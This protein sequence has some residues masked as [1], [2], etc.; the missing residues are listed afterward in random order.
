METD[1]NKKIKLLAGSG[2]IVLVTYIFMKRLFLIFLPFFVALLV[3]RALERPVGFLS[4]RIGGKRGVYAGI[5]MVLITLIL[6][7][8][9]GFLVYRFFAE[10]RS[11]VGNFQYNMVAV[12]Q[13][14]AR[15]CLRLDDFLGLKSG[16]CIKCA[17][18]FENQIGRMVDD[19]KLSVILGKCLSVSIPIVRGGIVVLASFFVMIIGVIYLSA[20]LDNIRRAR[21]KSV[22]RRE[23]GFV[24]DSLNLLVSV[25][26]RVQLLILLVNSLVCVLALYLT[27]NPYALLFGILIGILD[28]LPFFGTGTV[29]IPWAAGLLIIKNVP[30]ALILLGAYVVTYFVREIM[31]SKLMGK[32][33]GI[34]PFTMLM[35]IFVGIFIYGPLGFIMGPISYCIIKPLILCLKTDLESDKIGSI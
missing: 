3:A 4:R 13:N 22:F 8:G 1:Y 24:Y 6:L 23:I 29:L 25:Y 21:H 5:I 28:M 19:N 12:K 11:F 14:L 30:Q 10:L 32:K 35:V 26:F 9:V 17:E 33:M 27:K 15:I 7:G 16:C 31:E 2:A 34:N 18:Y 20:H